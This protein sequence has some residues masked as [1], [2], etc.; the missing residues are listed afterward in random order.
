M[1]ATRRTDHLILL[2]SLVMYVEAYTLQNAPIFKIVSPTL[3]PVL[4]YKWSTT[5]FLRH[6]QITS[7]YYTYTITDTATATDAT[8]TFTTVAS[9]E[10]QKRFRANECRNPDIVNK[11]FV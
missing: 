9:D 5:I 7:F 2:I 3:F 10:D 6:L 8:D 4:R 11:Y 1:H